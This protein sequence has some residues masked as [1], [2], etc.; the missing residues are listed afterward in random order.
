[1]INRFRSLV[2]D[3]ISTNQRAFVPSR[4]T[5]DMLL[6]LLTVCTQSN[7]TRGRKTICVLTSWMCLRRMTVWIGI[8]W[9]R[10][11][12]S[13]VFEGNGCS[14]LWVVFSLELLS[15]DKRIAAWWS[16]MF[17]FVPICCWCSLS[18]IMKNEVMATTISLVKVTRRAPGISHLLFADDILLFFKANAEQAST[19]KIALSVKICLV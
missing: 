10:F 5:M 11:L 15:T 19:I 16:F 17:V 18:M 4:L 9:K 2:H 14:G 3:I 12:R 8:S 1:M 13:W 6:L 7:N